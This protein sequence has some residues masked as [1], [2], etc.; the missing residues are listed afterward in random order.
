M[1]VLSLTINQYLPISIR[2]LSYFLICLTF[3]PHY[4]LGVASVFSHWRLRLTTEIHY[5][6][7]SRS[8]LGCLW[9]ALS[10]SA[11]KEKCTASEYFMASAVL[12]VDRG[13]SASKRKST[14]GEKNGGHPHTYMKQQLNPRITGVGFWGHIEQCRMSVGHHNCRWFLSVSPV[15][16]WGVTHLDSLAGW[17]D[18]DYEL[19]E[20]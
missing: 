8:I 14:F 1:C 17:T 9:E 4:F 16:L 6:L 12:E 15:S 2:T 3:S 7:H 19:S 20:L 10:A 5:T 18:R 13:L 11:R